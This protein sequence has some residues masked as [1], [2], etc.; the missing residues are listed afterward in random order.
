MIVFQVAMSSST[1]QPWTC[2]RH[3]SYRG[4]A[5]A[6][7]HDCNMIELVHAKWRHTYAATRRLSGMHV[8]SASVMLSIFPSQ[9]F[10]FVRASWRREGYWI[11]PKTCNSGR[12]HNLIK[13]PRTRFAA[14]HQVSNAH[15]WDLVTNQ[16]VQFRPFLGQTYLWESL[17]F[18]DPVR[19]Q[20]GISASGDR[21]IQCRVKKHWSVTCTLVSL[22]CPF[23]CNVSFDVSFETQ[24]LARPFYDGYWATWQG[25]SLKWFEIEPSHGAQACPP[26]SFRAIC[27]LSIVGFREVETG[28]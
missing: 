11:P 9:F 12:L 4:C 5:S 3:S 7:L 14:A 27:V 21:R 1:H 16:N 19:E 15:K 22:A 28:K 26:C 25:A 8:G 23:S 10:R 24:P 6:S 20:L 2:L 17:F 18:F 13:R